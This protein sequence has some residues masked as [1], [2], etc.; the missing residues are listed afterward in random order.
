[1]Q[2]YMPHISNGKILRRTL[3]IPGVKGNVTIKIS[4]TG[5]VFKAKGTKLGVSATWPEIVNSCSTPRSLPRKFD[6]RPCE[7]LSHQADAQIRR[8][9]K[10]SEQRRDMNLAGRCNG[11]QDPELRT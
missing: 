7:F 5:I 4:S 6:K 11:S 9:A 3:A 2:T 1:M 10:R 8:Q